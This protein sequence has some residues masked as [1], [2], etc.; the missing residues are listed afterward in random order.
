MEAKPMR[1]STPEREGI[2]SRAIERYLRALQAQGMYMHSVLFVRHGKI[3][4]EAYYKPFGP[5]FRHRLYSCSKSFVSVAV[6]VLAERGF[7]NLSDKCVDYFPELSAGADEYLRETTIRDLLRMAAPYTRGANYSPRDPNWE[8]TFFTDEVSHVPGTVF[9]YCTSGTTMLCAIIRRVTGGDFLDV[10]RPAFDEIGV[11]RDIF[12]IETPEGIQWGGSGVCATPREFAKFANLCMH[13]GLH[14]G[15]QLL[16]R[17][18]MMEATSRQIDNSLYAGNLDA[19]QGYGYQF[20]RT[21]NGGFAFYGMGGQYALCFP[22][23][24]F[25]LVTTGY[26]ELAMGSRMEIFGALWR[27]V[28]PELRDGPLPEDEAAAADLKMRMDSLV[29]AHAEGAADSPMRAQIDGKTYLMRENAMGMKRV[30]FDFADGEAVMRYENATGAHALR[31]GILKNVEQEFAEIY[32]GRRIGVPMGKGYDCFCSAAW[33][34]EDT[35]MLHCHVADIHLGQLRMAAAFKGNTLTLN[36]VK[37]AEW[38]LDEYQGFASGACG[39]E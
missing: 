18:Y 3:V 29:L 19:A 36:A 25:M 2:P 15:K 22:E 26:E 31:F 13:Y 8:K 5:E 17:A 4:S 11:S 27:E 34:A 32:S 20:W 39:R 23:K 37:H 6:G 38:F 1:V 9:S 10:L 33:T 12:S 7:I 14:E 28:F 24:D 35:L 16:P 21:Q 30:R